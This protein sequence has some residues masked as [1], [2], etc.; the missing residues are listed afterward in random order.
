MK[1]KNGGR[2][3]S[4]EDVKWLVPTPLCRLTS[5]VSMNEKASSI[6]TFLAMSSFQTE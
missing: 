4:D 3:M 2:G 6:A 1:Q 5:D